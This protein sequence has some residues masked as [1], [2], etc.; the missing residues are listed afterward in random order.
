MK[1]ETMLPML[2][3]DEIPD[4]EALLDEL[5]GLVDGACLREFV[6]PVPLEQTQPIGKKVWRIVSA[7]LFY[8]LLAALV[9]GAFFIS[10]GDKTPVFGYSFMNV[11]TWSMEPDIPQ[12]S[13]VIVKQ[14]DVSAIQIG[15]D[16]TYMIDAETSVT[17]RVI[18]IIEEFNGTGERGFETQGIA[19]DTPDFEV[20]PAMN[21]AGVVRACI[22]RIG[23]WLAWLSA[24]LLITAGFTAGIVV[25]AVLLRGAL[26]KNPGRD[27]Q[28]KRIKNVG[29]R[30]LKKQRE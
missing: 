25:L 30:R 27:K 2:W 5:I 23:N 7:V 6:P 17:H 18:G 16:I 8:G 14:V 13:L 4:D 3:H 29:L 24:N 26:K 19:N 10:Q 21:V 12:G 9:A 15:D 11:L 28:G 22:P 20:V 1:A